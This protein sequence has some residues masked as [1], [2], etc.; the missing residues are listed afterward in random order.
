MSLWNLEYT[1]NR[2]KVKKNYPTP[3][4]IFSMLNVGSIWKKKNT[5]VKSDIEKWTIAKKRPH[6]NHVVNTSIRSFDFNFID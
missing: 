5:F 3:A 1:Q 6:I 4:R 2:T